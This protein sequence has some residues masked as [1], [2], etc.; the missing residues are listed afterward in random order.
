MNIDISNIE[1]NSVDTI[2]VAEKMKPDTLGLT[3]SFR[4]IGSN[5]VIE[6]PISL[7]GCGNH[8]GSPSI[9]SRIN[10]AGKTYQVDKKNIWIL[11]NYT[12][13]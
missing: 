11:L 7:I 9:R 13:H 5:F 4:K 10:A 2:R 6:F 12:G 1:I 3:G 8:W